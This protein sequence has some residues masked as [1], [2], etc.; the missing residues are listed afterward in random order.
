MTPDE[1]IADIETRMVGMSFGNVNYLT[2]NQRLLALRAAHN[3][4]RE[5]RAEQARKEADE[6]WHKHPLGKIAVFVA[7]STLL[8]CVTYL[9]FTHFGIRL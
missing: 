9:V 7:G 2:L 8:A 4:V 5:E 1:E 6:K 3:V